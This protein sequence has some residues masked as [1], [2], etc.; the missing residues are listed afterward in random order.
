MVSIYKRQIPNIKYDY[1]NASLIFSSH[2]LKK[3]KSNKFLMKH[4]SVYKYDINYVKNIY[5]H[6]INLLKILETLTERPVT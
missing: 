6:N 3:N 4:R 5:R 1:T 2:L